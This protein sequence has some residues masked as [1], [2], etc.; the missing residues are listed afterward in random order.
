MR[1]FLS[2]VRVT[3]KS[4]KGRDE[5]IAV[6]ILSVIVFLYVAIAS[7]SKKREADNK[8]QI[9]FVESLKKA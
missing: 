6:V 4:S 1:P 2:S 8:A 5:L 9:E 7:Y 3:R